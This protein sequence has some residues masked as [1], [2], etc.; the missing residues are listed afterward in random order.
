[1][2][3]LQVVKYSADDSGFNAD[4]S[5]L[6]SD[7]E[8]D[9]AGSE[10]RQPSPPSPPVVLVRTPQAS[11][12]PLLLI[13][14]QTEYS[15]EIKNPKRD[16]NIISEHNKFPPPLPV[17]VRQAGQLYSPARKKMFQVDSSHYFIPKK[18]GRRYKPVVHTTG[19]SERYLTNFGHSRPPPSPPPRKPVRFP[20]TLPVRPDYRSTIEFVQ[21][22]NKNSSN[23]TISTITPTTSTITST[24]TIETTTTTRPVE[25]S[26]S[27]QAD[28]L[29]A[30]HP[31]YRPASY[32]HRHHNSARH[33]KH[34]PRT[35]YSGGNKNRLPPPW[36]RE[37]RKQLLPAFHPD[38]QA[39]N[40]VTPLP[41]EEKKSLILTT[42]ELLVNLIRRTAGTEDHQATVTPAA[43]PGAEED[44]T[45]APT[46]VEMDEFLNVEDVEDTTVAELEDQTET[47]K[48][49]GTEAEQT[50]DIGID[51]EQTTIN[52][53]IIS[54]TNNPISRGEVNP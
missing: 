10:G 16:L 44:V 43:G 23:T 19:P 3:L 26:E 20:P 7:P 38:Y 31:D 34:L 8:S 41:E 18:T 33:K 40:Y 22:Q 14:E 5:Y 39:E 29:P 11:T 49:V 4:V 45:T 1:M 37:R 17:V 32:H 28:L 15:E 25:R 51:E 30:F 48:I 21:H 53:S 35:N 47:S 13:S 24:T 42:T 2:S 6:Q 54:F 36:L 52:S 12:D 46:I 50:T 9:R 27:V